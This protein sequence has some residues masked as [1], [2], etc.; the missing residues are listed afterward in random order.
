V[1]KYG[2]IVMRDVNAFW[3]K[4]DGVSTEYYNRDDISKHNPFPRGQTI[5]RTIFNPYESLKGVDKHQMWK[6][7]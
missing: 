5:I 6:W 2:D 4:Q 7:F 1:E 3:A